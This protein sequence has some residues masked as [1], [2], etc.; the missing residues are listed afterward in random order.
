MS[1]QDHQR[2]PKPSAPTNTLEVGYFDGQVMSGGQV[3]QGYQPYWTASPGDGPGDG[4]EYPDLV[5]ALLAGHAET[6][7]V[8]MV[9]YLNTRFCAKGE[10]PRQLAPQE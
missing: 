3:I 9:Q 2:L 1:E 4:T 10:P 6:A 7:D 5:S 8:V